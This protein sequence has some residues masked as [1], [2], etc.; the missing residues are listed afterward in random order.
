MDKENVKVSKEYFELIRLCKTIEFNYEK[1]RNLLKKVDVNAY[2]GDGYTLLSRA[3]NYDNYEMVKLLVESGADINKPIGHCD[4]KDETVIWDL[5]YMADEGDSETDEEAMEKLDEENNPRIKILRYLITHGAKID[6][7]PYQ[8]YLIPYVD[9]SI[10]NDFDQSDQYVHRCCFFKTILALC[11]DLPEYFTDYKPVDIEKLHLYDVIDTKD[12]HGNWITVIVD[13][14]YATVRVFHFKLYQ[15]RQYKRVVGQV[16]SAKIEESIAMK[17]I[18]L[19]SDE[20]IKYY[21][22][23]LNVYQTADLLLAKFKNRY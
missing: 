8:E 20:I 10:W 1:A 15:F 7:K 16:L 13:E 3:C 12:K 22:K 11:W 5:Q 9:S 19:Y 6:I 4:E 23:K 21:D 14:T 17:L 2:C 18:E